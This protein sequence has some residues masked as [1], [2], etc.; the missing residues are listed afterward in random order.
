[1]D[2]CPRHNTPARKWYEFAEG[3][4]VVTYTGC[5]CALYHA[6]ANTVGEGGGNDKLCA[7]YA[8]ASGFARLAQAVA[9]SY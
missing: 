7:D 9:R 8:E 1:M 3:I 5:H 4:T 6:G 2:E